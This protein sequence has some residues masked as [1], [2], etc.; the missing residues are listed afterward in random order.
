MTT[1]C[2]WPLLPVRPP[3]DGAFFVRSPAGVNGATLQENTLASEFVVIRKRFPSAVHRRKGGRVSGFM[4]S[5]PTLLLLAYFEGAEATIEKFAFPLASDIQCRD[6]RRLDPLM[7][8][9]PGTDCAALRYETKS[10]RPAPGAFAHTTGFSLPADLDTASSGA[11]AA[12]AGA[13]TVG[14]NLDPE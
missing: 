5:T 6:R 14:H 2:C 9:V 3:R 7:G 11:R 10:P 13:F 4:A 12:N 1:G 8:I